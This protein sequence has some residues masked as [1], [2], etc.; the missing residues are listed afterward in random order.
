MFFRPHHRE[1]FSRYRRASMAACV[2]AIALAACSGG[3]AETG[4]APKTQSTPA[5]TRESSEP[6]IEIPTETPTVQPDT[7]RSPG[8]GKALTATS[9]DQTVR[10]GGRDRLF[11]LVLPSGYTGNSPRP[12]VLNWHGYG[13]NAVE[14]AVYSEL[15]VKGPAAGYA[16]I[17]PQG[18]GDPALWNILTRG[19]LDDVG[20]AED[21]ISWAGDSLCIDTDRVYSTGI[22]NGAGMSVFLACEIPQRIAAIAPVA[23]VNLVA[24]C[25]GPPISV[26]AFHGLADQVVPYTGGDVMGRRDLPFPGVDDALAAWAERDGCDGEPARAS[27]SSH[28]DRRS[29]KGCT[30]GSDVVLYTVE[31]GGHTWPGS[32]DVP[33]LGPVTDEIDAADLILAFFDGH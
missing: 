4:S 31:G 2:I 7:L 5:S 11:R 13:S 32:L 28:V 15:E 1:R 29:Y 14:Q 18:T 33:R 10:S 12:L 22:S 3:K 26:I 19:A 20:F 8:C 16:V 27:V 6:P 30:E 9:P 24:P 23:G 17:T 25:P 21:L